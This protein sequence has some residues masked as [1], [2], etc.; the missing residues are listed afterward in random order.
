VLEHSRLALLG[1]TSSGRLSHSRYALRTRNITE[2]VPPGVAEDFRV[3]FG[4][5]G[6][7]ARRHGVPITV[8]LLPDRRQVFSPSKFTLQKTLLTLLREAGVD[9]LD[10][11]PVFLAQPDKRALYLPDWHYTDLGN[12]VV[13]DALRAQPAQPP[14][15]RAQ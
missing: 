10:V 9:A 14:Q 1:W 3:M 11:A 15:A 8:V 13:I 7:L 2:S 12:R 5:L 4:E 6:R